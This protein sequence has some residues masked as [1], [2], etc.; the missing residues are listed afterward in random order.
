MPSGWRSI[1]YEGVQFSVP[2]SFKTQRGTFDPGDSCGRYA[3]VF[4][5]VVYEGTS[6]S[7]PV[8]SADVP[9]DELT[10]ID[11]VWIRTDDEHGGTKWALPTATPL[12]N[13]GEGSAVVL[14]VDPEGPDARQPILQIVVTT[15]KGRRVLV[16][17]GLGPDPRVAGGI[18]A[19][20]RVD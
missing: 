19:S 3:E 4:R 6:A 14:D 20:L 12:R 11:G 1:D 17:V 15:S 7:G 8:C 18:V 10:G 2:R 5:D 9:L 16:N 13:V